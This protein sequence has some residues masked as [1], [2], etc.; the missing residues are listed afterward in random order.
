MA[1][2]THGPGTTSESETAAMAAT[3]WGGDDSTRQFPMPKACK[4]LAMAEDGTTEEMTSYVGTET[5]A[6]LR[7]R[8]AMERNSRGRAWSR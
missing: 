6:K 5:T 1:G 4:L 8:L 7:L 2:Y 3:R